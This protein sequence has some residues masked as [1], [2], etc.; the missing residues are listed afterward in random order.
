MKYKQIKLSDKQ[1]SEKVKK[2]IDSKNILD[3]KDM[4]LIEEYCS[5]KNDK[6]RGLVILWWK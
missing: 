6:E 5:R 4:E 3:D 2:I 1:L